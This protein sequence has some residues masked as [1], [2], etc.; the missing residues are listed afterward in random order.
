M[1][2]TKLRYIIPHSGTGVRFAKRDGAEQSVNCRR[3]CGVAG[4]ASTLGDRGEAV[5]AS[6]REIGLATRRSMV[7]W[8][9]DTFQE[10][11]ALRARCFLH[12]MR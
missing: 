8:S 9:R 2:A 3:L 4:K 10:A 6:R 11:R 1:A 7:L 5:H 12:F